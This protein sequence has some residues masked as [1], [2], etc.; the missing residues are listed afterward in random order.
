[1]LE[2]AH[3]SFKILGPDL[4]QLVLQMLICLQGE[5]SVYYRRSALRNGVA[6]DAVSID[7]DGLCFHA[8]SITLVSQPFAVAAFG[9]A[10]QF[11]GSV[12]FY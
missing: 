2:L 10:F 7:C 12:G 6:H 1:M 8:A 4:Q 3:R 5:Q 9:V 11:E